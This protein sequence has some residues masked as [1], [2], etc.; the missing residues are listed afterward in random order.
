MPAPFAMAV[1]YKFLAQKVA[2]LPVIANPSEEMGIIDR[3]P[4]IIIN[5]HLPNQA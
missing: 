5:E 3:A 4:K 2:H 1:E